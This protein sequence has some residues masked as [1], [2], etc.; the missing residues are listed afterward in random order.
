MTTLKSL[1]SLIRV[2]IPIG[3]FPA[4]FGREPAI[5]FLLNIS[6]ESNITQTN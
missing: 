4:K 1:K 6:H 2:M 3:S 5:T